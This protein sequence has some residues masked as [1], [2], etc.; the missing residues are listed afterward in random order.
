MEQNTAAVMARFKSFR[1][2]AAAPQ[3]VGKEGREGP[4]TSQGG[5]EAAEGTTPDPGNAGIAGPTTPE[6][7]AG[8]SRCIKNPRKVWDLGT[9]W[10]PGSV[11]RI[12]DITAGV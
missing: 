1:Q 12:V 7:T 9:R 6:T 8:G 3:E 4:E 5:Q 2:P 10:A 11:D